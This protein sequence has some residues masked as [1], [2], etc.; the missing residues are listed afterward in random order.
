MSND[1]LI[2]QYHEDAAVNMPL[3]LY[4]PPDKSSFLPPPHMSLPFPA[5]PSPPRPPVML[6]TRRASGTV[7]PRVSW[8]GVEVVVVVLAVIVVV[9][10]VV[11]VMLVFMISV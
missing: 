6:E 2:H 7:R 4:F 5:P 1:Q 9:V 3:T 8:H 10:V 11:V